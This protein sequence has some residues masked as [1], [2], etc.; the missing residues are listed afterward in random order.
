MVS[1]RFLDGPPSGGSRLGRAQVD[2]WCRRVPRTQGSQSAQGPTLG[3][4]PT[5]PQMAFTVPHLKQASWLSRTNWRITERRMVVSVPSCAA[6]RSSRLAP[7]RRRRFFLLLPELIT[8][9]E[10]TSDG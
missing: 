5:R 2:L 1:V 4:C 8:G 6:R 10:T 7:E 9:S 3:L